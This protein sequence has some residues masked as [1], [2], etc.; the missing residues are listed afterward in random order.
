MIERDFCDGE[1][2]DNWIKALEI[3]S[4]DGMLIFC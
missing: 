4:N 2:Y 1:K 3:A